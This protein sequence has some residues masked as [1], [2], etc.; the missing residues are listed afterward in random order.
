[1]PPLKEKEKSYI[2]IWNSSFV[3]F[4]DVTGEK[5]AAMVL[6]YQPDCHICSAVKPHFL[7]AAKGINPK[8]PGGRGK[9][10][11]IVDCNKESG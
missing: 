6:F 4:V 7:K 1:M 8:T 11:A 9:A 2:G 10:F 5:D 3:S